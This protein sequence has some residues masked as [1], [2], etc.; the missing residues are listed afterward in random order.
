MD[1]LVS[2]MAMQGF[3]PHGYCFQWSSQILG[4]MIVADSLTAIAYF[5]IHLALL[6]LIDSRFMDT[7]SRNMFFLFSCFIFFCGT[8]HIFDII[9][10][11]YP[12]YYIQAYVKLATAFTSVATAVLMWPLVKAINEAPLRTRAIIE[13]ELD[14]AKARI[15]ELEAA[16]QK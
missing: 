12:A 7:K 14:A 16:Q 13:V 6:A 8:T 3:L 5:S 10:I 4:M 2:L 15:A 11:W 1:S 9:T